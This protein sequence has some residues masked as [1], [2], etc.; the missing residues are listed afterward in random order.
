MGVRTGPGAPAWPSLP[1]PASCSCMDASLAIK[2]VFE[3]FQSVI[4][5]SGVGTLS[6][7]RPQPSTVGS[8]FPPSPAQVVPTVPTTDA[9]PTGH[10]PQ[11]SGLPPCHHGDLYHDA[12]PGVPLP[13]GA[14]ERV[15]PGQGRWGQGPPF[16]RLFPL[17]LRHRALWLRA[18]ILDSDAPGLGATFPCG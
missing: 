15:V 18:Q 8:W 6:P 3:R 5:T 9:V 14:W 12:G 10:L 13:Y 17:W 1:S 7:H 16:L 4:I 2:P 11:D